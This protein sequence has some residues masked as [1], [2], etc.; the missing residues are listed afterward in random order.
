MFRATDPFEQF[1][2]EFGAFAAGVFI[3][4]GIPALAVLYFLTRGYR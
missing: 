2:Q 1:M 4:C 3:F